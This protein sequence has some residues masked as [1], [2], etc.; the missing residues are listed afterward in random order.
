MFGKV[1]NSKASITYDTTTEWIQ[2]Q[3]GNVE[4]KQLACIFNTDAENAKLHGIFLTAIS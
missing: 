4:I 2:K 3:M 1:L